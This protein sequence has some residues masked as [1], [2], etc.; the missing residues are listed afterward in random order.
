MD[1]YIPKIRLVAEYLV[2]NNFAELF[3]KIAASTAHHG[4]QPTN[5]NELPTTVLALATCLFQNYSDQCPLLCQE[6]GRTGGVEC[7]VQ[8]VSTLKSPECEFEDDELLEGAF[9]CALGVLH[10]CIRLCVENRSRYRRADA[11]KI[12]G[13]LRKGDI[14]DVNLLLILAYIVDEEESE[15]L[16]KSEGCVRML[17]ELLKEAVS[18]DDHFGFTE[19]ESYYSATELLDGLNHLAINDAIKAEI[20]KHG[21]M[22]CIIRMLQPDFSE[23]EHVVATQALWNLSFLDSIKHTSEVQ[24]TLPT[25]QSLA[26]SESQPIREASSYA[27]WEIQDNQR[28]VE[29]PNYDDHP[30][31]YQETV[32]AHAQSGPSGHVMISYQWDSQDRVT[33]IRDKLIQTGYKV[34]MDVDKMRGDILDAMA[35]AVEKSDVILICMTERYKD[36]TSCR[37]EAKYASKKNKHIVPLLLEADYDPDGWLGIL[38]GT[39]LF[40]KFCSDD[41]MTKKHGRTLQRTRQSWTSRINITISSS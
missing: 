35:D 24:A 21:G 1:I 22:H 3:V 6:F 11:V 25:L 10:N 13:G 23:E 32:E 41:E 37:S 29:H 8:I 5:E 14:S 17:I 39:K 30:P 15:T 27:V 9:N 19:N 2:Q 7:V 18:R 40:Y 4:L 33:A 16:A 28:T 20:A 34:W 38:L 12:L 36:S 26:T 31:S